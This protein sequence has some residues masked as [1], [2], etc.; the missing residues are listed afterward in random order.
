MWKNVSRLRTTLNEAACT[1]APE[2]ACRSYQRLARLGTLVRCGLNTSGLTK[3][4][5]DKIHNQIGDKINEV[6]VNQA[7]SDETEDA[8]AWHP[9]SL[10]RL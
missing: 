4:T 1:L 3:M 7:S 10:V 2:Q 5:P 8:I 9:V 6:M